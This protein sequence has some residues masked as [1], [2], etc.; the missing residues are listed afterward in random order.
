MKKV[1]ISARQIVEEIK[2]A[3]GDAELCER[4]RLSR[5]SLFCLKKELLERKLVTLADL[6]VQCS[7]GKAR[8][9]LNVERFL[10][11]FR[12]NPDDVYLM[13]KYSLSASQLKRVYVS[14]ME[15][16]LLSEYEYSSRAVQVPEVE[17]ART[18]P[19]APSAAVSLVE[20][21]V[22]EPCFWDFKHERQQTELP[23]DFFRDHSGVKIGQYAAN[24]PDFECYHRQRKRAPERT[25]APKSTVVELVVADYCPNCG[26]AKNSLSPDA[27]LG[28]G[29][30]FAKAVSS[31]QPQIAI[32]PHDPQD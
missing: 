5:K 11:D 19:H 21:R 15:K 13:E 6:R 16:N 26:L 12:R 27:C 2:S 4:Y 22:D 28:C 9:K 25:L 20:D 7:N 29:I 31:D 18:T 14:M 8:K 17:Q 3:M 10:Y 30:V 23:G 1:R 24:T 32:W